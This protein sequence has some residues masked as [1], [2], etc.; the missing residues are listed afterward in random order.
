MYTFKPVRYILPP[1]IVYICMFS[2]YNSYVE[3][4]KSEWHLKAELNRVEFLKI[5]SR[6]YIVAI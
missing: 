5:Y 3:F 2:Q 6:T 1:N 4:I